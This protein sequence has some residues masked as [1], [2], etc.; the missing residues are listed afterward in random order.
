MA[1]V[2]LLAL[3]VGL[4]VHNV[5][6]ALLWD[7]GVRGTS[8][9]VA[10]AW[11]EVLLLVGLG[12]ALAA[13]G[14]LPGLLWADR[15]AVAFTVMVVLAWAV[16]QSWLGGEATQRGELF[17]LRH[18][19]LPVA[20][21]A[22]GRLLTLDRRWWRRIG[23]TVVGLACAVATWGLVD[24]YLVPLQ[25]WRDSGVPGWFGEQLGLVYECL[26][27][28]P[29]NWILNTGDEEH[30]VRRLVSTLL[31]PLAS[32]YLL[33][34]AL[35]LLA[36]IRPR[37]LTVAA[38][39][40]AYVGLLWTH[41]RAAF[42]G[43]AVGLL[44][45]AVVRRR[46]EPAVLAGGSVVVAA[47]LVAVF[48]TIGPGASYTA[49]ERACLR[50][51]AAEE[52]APSEGSSLTG[53]DSSTRSHLR[54]LRDGIETVLR[55]PQGHG[56]GNAGVVALRTGVDVKA[57]ESTYTEIGVDTGLLG[58]VAFVGWLVALGWA[59]ARRSPWLTACVA[60]VAV[61]GLQ[62]DVIGVHWVSVTVFALAGAALRAPPGASAPEEAL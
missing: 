1:R 8:L 62:T 12:A 43:L 26:S 53:D 29:E 56:L 50:A 10:A 9:D 58:L 28:L 13:T 38:G 22:L 23:L 19:L 24:V 49:T 6:M 41:T 17:A 15:L 59:L 21:Y 47:A 42:V 55:H 27:G 4:A 40:V 11:K 18:H 52:G 7:A 2:A 48:P 39:A 25:W 54:N 14:S 32:A 36:A 5:A 34:V 20:A 16:P 37:R 60:A 35:L 3:V 46:W 57:G 33:V 44:V 30:P 45:L 61:I 31:S 51:N